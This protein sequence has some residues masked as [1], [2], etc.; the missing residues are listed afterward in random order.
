[1]SIMCLVDD[2]HIPLYRIM[3]ISAVPHFCGA[4]ECERE[5]EY[6]LQLEHGEVVWA[7]REE[8]DAVLSALEKWQGGL[9]SEEAEW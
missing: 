9:G 3:W 2:K 6:E 5:G 8:R 4:E 1:M 7:N